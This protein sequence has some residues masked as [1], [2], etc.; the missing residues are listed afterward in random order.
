MAGP[1]GSAVAAQRTAQ[2]PG[3]KLL[4]ADLMPVLVA[5][6][7]RR[8][9]EQRTLA[10]AEFLALVTEDLDELRDAGF[11][12]P[13]P[14]Q[15]YVASWIR[16]GILIRRPTENRE[17][18][19][20]LSRSAADAV[21]FVAAVDQP[22]SSVTSSR[23]SNVADL[24]SSL[25]RDS[26]PVPTSRLEAL[27]A[28]RDALD[29]EI[30]RV[31]SGEFEPVSD[32]VASERLREILRLA[33]EVPGD[34]AK[35]ADDLDHL[36][37]SLREQIINHEGSRGGVLER[38]FAGVDVIE[39]S[40]AGRTF[41]AFHRLLLDPGL[42]D[43]FDGAVDAVLQRAFTEALGTDD[44]AFLRQ[45]LTTLQ[46]ESAQVRQTL[47]SFSRSL[48]RFVETQEYREHKRLAATIDRAE[49]AVFAALQELSPI[50][51]TGRAIDL[52]SMPI[53]SIGSWTLHNPA[54]LRSTAEVAT[55]DA[56]D[57]DLE[58]L[59]ALVRLTE[60]DFPE[61]QRAVAATLSEVPGPT[62]ADV[63]VRFPA[64][65]GLASVVGLLWLATEYALRTPGEE[66]WSW[67]SPGGRTKNVRAPRYVFG[68]VPEHWS[69][70]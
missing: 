22:Q 28:Q 24:L 20:E 23:L 62:V 30:A 37:Q 46:R 57:L 59:R 11:P 68:E 52:T 58:Q 55:H 1:T 56:A 4:R 2:S 18:T 21:R 49:Q 38:V 50:H 5:I 51:P 33:E 44:V 25:A 35:V 17:E 14:A 16:D 66:V 29:A 12:L 40:D 65:Q 42:T 45:F 67:T 47:T 13:Q 19:V 3:L 54:D 31:E 70:P 53:S 15:Q 64:T 43:A 8:F 60:I 10:Y 41:T 7:A 61:L 63:L 9:A 27:R 48:R 34:F 36:N 39:E 32:A 69:A 6:L 26:D